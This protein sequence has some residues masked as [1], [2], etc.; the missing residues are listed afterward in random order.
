MASAS[1]LVLAAF[2]VCVHLFRPT[3]GKPVALG[4]S[5]N[6]SPPPCPSGSELEL[7]HILLK[8]TAVLVSSR[9]GTGSWRTSASY[10]ERLEP[11]DSA[12]VLTNINYNDGGLYEFTCVGGEDVRIQLDV[13][14]PIQFSVFENE[15]VL[16]P[17]HAVTAGG[18][19]KSVRWERKEK[20]KNVARMNVASNKII[21][22]DEF[23]SRVSV[24]T[25]WF[26]K[27]DFTLTLG[28]V[29]LQDRGD[30]TCSIQDKYGTS[31]IFPVV[32]RLTVQKTRN[33]TS[34][35]QSG[36]L[37]VNEGMS[38]E[39]GGQ[40][41]CVAIAVVV[42]LVLCAV[43][44]GIGWWMRSRRFPPLPPP[45][46]PPPPRAQRE[47]AQEDAAVPLVSQNEPHA[48]PNGLEPNGHR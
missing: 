7:Q 36:P 13:V 35:E 21:L 32:A 5:F 41:T 10:A 39:N 20:S 47:G 37:H 40:T 34:T 45:P 22:T 24:P 25:D 16:L 23:K 12:L 15:T 1:L 46:P 44:F 6:F 43:A 4:D 14:V 30:W 2:L 8:D 19:V 29:R 42:A 9:D 3:R 48:Q 28:P 11:S 33:E 18:D 27:G 38:Q 31:R 26:S 17:C